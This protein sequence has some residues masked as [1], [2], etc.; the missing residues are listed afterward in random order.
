MEERKEIIKTTEFP[1]GVNRVHIPILTEEEE[2]ER[3]K[4]I[5]DAGEKLLKAQIRCHMEKKGTV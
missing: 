5:R 1:D 2:R 3:Q 4:R